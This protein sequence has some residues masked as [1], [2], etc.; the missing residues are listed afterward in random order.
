MDYSLYEHMDMPDPNIAIKIA[1]YKPEITGTIFPSHWHEHIELL[2]I[3]NGSIEAKCD[4]SLFCANKGDLIIFNSNELHRGEKVSTELDYY[5]I[6]FDI[7]FLKGHNIDGSLTR[8]IT[9][10]AQNSILFKNH[11]K[12][13]ESIS[14]CILTIVHEYEE[15]DFAYEL[16]I[17]S[18]LSRLVVILLRNHIGKI[19]APNEYDIYNKKAN[20]IK[21]VLKYIETNYTK[22]LS[23]DLLADIAGM[24]KYYFCHSFKAVTGQ[25][26]NTYVNFIRMTAAESMLRNTD[27]S[28]TDIALSVGFDDINYFSRTYK[29]HMGISPTAARK[30]FERLIY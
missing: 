8:Y 26:L 4:N 7:S 23:L 29:K 9:P 16:S 25:T 3:I 19:L 12:E 5:C 14:E 6:I 1:R 30:G 13:N 11:I 21:N 17:K 10:I 2:F 15:K 20:K 22:K 28:I 27:L 24:N 18:L